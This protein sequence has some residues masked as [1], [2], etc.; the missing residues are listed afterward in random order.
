[1]IKT[2]N[3]E[4]TTLKGAYGYY[5]FIQ[6]LLNLTYTECP[7]DAARIHNKIFNSHL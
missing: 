7:N 2:Y 3:A 1:M 5:T 4:S 6:L